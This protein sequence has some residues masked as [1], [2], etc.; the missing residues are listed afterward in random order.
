MLAPRD[1]TGAI[2]AGGRGR[3]LGGA[4]KPLLL[5]DGATILARQRAVL[6]PRVAELLVAVAAGDAPLCA[7]LRHVEDPVADAGPLAGLVAALGASATPWL[8]AVAGDMPRLAPAVLD[9]LIARA[10]DDVDAVVGRV[11]GWPEPLCALWHRR[12]L[13]LLA[14]RLAARRLGVAAALADLA[15]AW[16]DEDELR[17]VDPAL[18]TFTNVNRP[19]DL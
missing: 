19:D 10:A 9:R 16:V 8:L 2:L 5:V 6:T 1:L 15:V 7:E 12:A 17:A 3:R 11:G 4:R 14:G 18:A 13:P